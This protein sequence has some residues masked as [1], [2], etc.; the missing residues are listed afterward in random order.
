[1]AK[2]E[3]FIE[4]KNK[5][6]QFHELTECEICQDEQHCYTLKHKNCCLSLCY[7]CLIDNTNQNKAKCLYCKEKDM[8]NYK[9]IT[10]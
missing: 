2:F 5:I 8:I 3:N 10:A 4:I 9:E 7:K 1:M 6:T